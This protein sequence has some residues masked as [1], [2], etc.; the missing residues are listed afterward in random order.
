MRSASLPSTEDPRYTSIAIA[1]HWAIAALIV[2]NLATGLIHDD[3]SKATRAWM[4]PLHIS[5]GLTILVLTV[6]RIV[7][8]ATHKPPAHLA[9][10]TRLEALLAGLTYVLFYALMLALPLTGWLLISAHPANPAHPVYLV[11]G[12]IPWPYIGGVQAMAVGAQKHF[13]HQ[14]GELHE[15]GGYV[16]L[17]LL[18]LH[19]AGALKHHFYDRLPELHRMMPRHGG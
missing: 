2:F 6:A 15:L 7:W 13:H 11:W 5:S 3:V 19:I 4:M 18:A 9:G 14:I 12:V 8:R 1:L 10:V 17:A 16:M